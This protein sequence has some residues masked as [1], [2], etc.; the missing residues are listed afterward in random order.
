MGM[1]YGK[2]HGQKIYFMKDKTCKRTV[3]WD[4]MFFHLEKKGKKNKI[5]GLSGNLFFIIGRYLN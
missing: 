4:N 3:Y 2:K 1:S 5:T